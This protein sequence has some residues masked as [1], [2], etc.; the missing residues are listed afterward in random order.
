MRDVVIA[1]AAR[2]PV[3]TFGGGL[4]DIPAVEL[5]KIAVTEAL[6]RGGLKP[7]QVEEVILGCVLTAGQGQNPARQVLIKAGI[8]KEV[9]ATTINKVCASGLKSVMMAGDAEAGLAGA[10]MR[11]ILPIRSAPPVR[12]AN[13]R[14]RQR[15]TGSTGLVNTEATVGF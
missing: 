15:M 9:P 10:V 12:T 6:K 14:S 1:S 3:G 5:G 11:S 8:P 13:G 4:R 7:E 2:T